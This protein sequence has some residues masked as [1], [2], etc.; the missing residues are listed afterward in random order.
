MIVLTLLGLAG[1]SADCGQPDQV[2]GTYAVFANVISAPEV[3]NEEAFPSYM[4]PVNGWTEWEIQ[5]NLVDQTQVV[6]LLDGQAY[7]AQ[8][9][10]DSL[11]CGRFDLKFQ[12]DYTSVNDTEH[13][14]VAD[15]SFVVFGAHLDGVWAWSEIWTGRNAQSGTFAALG[16]VAG[17]RVSE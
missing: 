8:G 9:S 5:W 12:G 10:W 2:N 4:S 16:Q 1:C 3:S 13:A 14:F 17:T 15:G 6:V 7:Q 11:E